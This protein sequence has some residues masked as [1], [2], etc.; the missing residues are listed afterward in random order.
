MN[1]VCAG[2]LANDALDVNVKASLITPFINALNVVPDLVT[3]MCVQVAVVI[4]PITF[5]LAMFH[6]LPLELDRN[7]NEPPD[8]I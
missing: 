4:V 7:F 5:S 6:E 2:R 1:S 8:A 3:A